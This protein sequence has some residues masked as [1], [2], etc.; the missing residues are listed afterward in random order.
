MPKKSLSAVVAAL[1]ATVGLAACSSGGSD[2]LV[3][4]SGRSENLVSPI[5]ERF[6]EESGIDIEVLRPTRAITLNALDLAFQRVELHADGKLVEATRDIGIDADAQTATFRVAKPWRRAST[7]SNC[8]T[9]ERSAPRPTACSRS[10]TRTSRARSAPCSP[11]SRIPTRAACCRPGTSRP[12][13][14]RS[15]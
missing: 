7:A 12:S 14:R 2:E 13:A 11:S 3:I 4:Y 10:T 8:A 9:A 1:V 15:S 6:E 5:L